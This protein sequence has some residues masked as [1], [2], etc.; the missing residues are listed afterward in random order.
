MS[1]YYHS[2]GLVLRSE[3]WREGDRLATILTRD[4]GK[5]RLQIKSGLK[6]GHKLSGH[7][8]PLTLTDISWARTRYGDT[9]IEASAVEGFYGLKN[10]LDLLKLAL[11]GNQLLEKFAPEGH[12]ENNLYELGLRWWWLLKGLAGKSDVIPEGTQQRGCLESVGDQDTIKLQIP[13]CAGMTK[14]TEAVLGAQTITAAFQWQ[15]LKQ[16]GLA[17]ET[18][19]CV[20]CGREMGTEGGALDAEAGGFKHRECGD[21]AG[22]IYTPAILKILD[23]FLTKPLEFWR[24]KSVP[25]ADLTVL[26]G[27]WREFVVFRVD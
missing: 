9:A 17:P 12:S 14:G 16:E 27:L 5:V 26:E 13:A 19:R 7:L 11:D 24:G 23:Q 22:Q 3:P 8:E 15:V 10:N 6:S 2:R 18:G 4:Y 25:A 1:E 20:V 21:S